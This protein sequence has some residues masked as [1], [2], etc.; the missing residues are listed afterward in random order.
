MLVRSREPVHCRQEPGWYRGKF[1][2]V[3]RKRG[4]DFIFIRMENG[5]FEI[6]LRKVILIIGG[7]TDD[8]AAFGYFV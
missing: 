5:D 1:V 6:L 3:P 7:N 4:T 8:E 2:S